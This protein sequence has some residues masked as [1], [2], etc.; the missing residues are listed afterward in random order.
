MILGLTLL[1][2]VCEE[3]LSSK[4]DLPKER[5]DELVN[6]FYTVAPDIRLFLTQMLDSMYLEYSKDSR[7]FNKPS[8]SQIAILCLET[9]KSLLGWIPSRDCM[10]SLPFLMKYVMINDDTFQINLIALDSIYEITDFTF[11]SRDFSEDLISIM[12]L[13]IGI[14]D[15]WSKLDLDDIDDE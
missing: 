10:E 13:F 4:N 3:F 5:K 1:K 8:L 12:K 2:M 6:N 9:L 7:F 14:F 11:L 15:K